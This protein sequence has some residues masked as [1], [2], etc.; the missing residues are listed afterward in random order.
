M[1]ALGLLLL[2]VAAALWLIPSRQYIFLPDRAHPVAPLVEVAG[3]HD[4]KDGGGIY[5]V[6][7]VVRKASLLER[8]F[9]GLH[10]GADLYPASRVVPPGVSGSQQSDVDAAEMRT[11]QRVAAAVA[12]RA[13][14]R[15]VAAVPDGALVTGV[16]PGLPA[17]GRLLPTD[18]I[19]A[20]DGRTVSSPDDVTRSMRGREPGDRVRFT[21]RRGRRRVTVELRTVAAAGDGRRAVVGIFLA[22]SERIDLPVRVSIDSRGVGGPSAGLAFALDVLEELGRNVDHGHRIAATGE[23]FLNG[24][25]GPIG[26]IK[27]KT[28]GAREAGVDAFLVPAGQNARDARK[29]AR[30][31]RIIPVKSFQQALRALATLSGT[32]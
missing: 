10:D 32:E 16:Q 31:L 11:S 12:L 13:L 1:L 6:D 17:E 18:V 7:V 27:Q 2:A 20:V 9:G 3:G 21:V 30:G 26:A 19:T 8:I 14:G 24:D 25:V 4:P 15:K 23:L 29:Y 22:Q 28:I 5:F